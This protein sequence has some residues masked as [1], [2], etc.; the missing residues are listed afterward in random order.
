LTCNPYPEDIEVCY[1]TKDKESDIETKIKSGPITQIKKVLI[2]SRDPPSRSNFFF[3]RSFTIRISALH[4]KLMK[5]RESLP[6]H[7]ICSW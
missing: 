2:N 4:I 1:I 3:H 7:M 6:I 5:Q